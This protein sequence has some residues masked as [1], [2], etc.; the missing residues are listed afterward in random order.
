M[1]FGFQEIDGEGAGLLATCAYHPDFRIN[2]EIMKTRDKQMYFVIFIC[3]SVILTLNSKDI[4]C[5]FN[6][7]VNFF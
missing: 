7:K 3:L 5:K 4:E 2:A 1:S 6:T